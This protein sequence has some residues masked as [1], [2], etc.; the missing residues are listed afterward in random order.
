[1][2]RHRNVE[3]RQITISLPTQLLRWATIEA[4]KN[5]QSISL[6]IS[7]LLEKEKENAVITN[8]TK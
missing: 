7:T 6:F 2:R 5:E 3:L 1:M 8:D 4:A